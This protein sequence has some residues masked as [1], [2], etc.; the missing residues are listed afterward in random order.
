[1]MG[2]IASVAA[3]LLTVA[4]LYGMQRTTPLYSEITSPIPVHA[5][6]GSPARTDDFVVGVVRAHL[7]RTIEA[8]GS[9][10]AD[11]TYTTS[12]VWVVVEGA[13]QAS[14]ESLT[15]GS[16]AWLGPNGARYGVS[17]RLST[18]PGT[19]GLE[20]LHPGVPRPFFVVFEVPESQ[21]SGATLLVA[22]S[23]LTP[24]AQEA[25]V[26]MTGVDARDIKATIRIGRGNQVVPWTL[27][28]E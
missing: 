13:A 7:A 3:L 6:L 12:G 25:W 17:W 28:V 5:K 15:L 14:H 8:R 24:L 18:L 26:E 2:R 23:A 21:V 9:L 22:R 20:Q 27:E 16:V 1:M 4:V 19:L 10:G 11:H